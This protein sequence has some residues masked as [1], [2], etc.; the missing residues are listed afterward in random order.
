MKKIVLALVALLMASTFVFAQARGRTPAPAPAAALPE[1]GRLTVE[2]F[3]RGSDG[4]RT[5]AHNNAWTNWIKEKVKKDLNIDVTF[6]PVGRWS[7]NTDIVNLMASGSAPDLC[8][9]YNLD[10]INDFR[11]KGGVFDLAPYIDSYLPDLKKL[12]GKDP[13]FPGKDLAYRDQD[14]KS[15]KIYSVVSYRTAIA[16]RN[17]FIRKDWLDKLGMPLPKNMGEYYQALKAFRDRDPGNVG[18]NRVV[19]LGVNQD[20]RWGL[21][22]FI[23]HFWPNNLSDRDRWIYT[24]ADRQIMMPGYKRGVQEMN[25]WYLEGLIFKDF[26]LMTTAD[27]FY[28]QIKSGVVGSFCQNWDFIYRTDMNILVDLRKNIPT[29]DYVPI[30]ITNNKMVMDKP[31]LR[32]FIPTFS[33]NKDAALKYLNWLAKPENYSFLQIGQAGVTHNMVNGIPQTIATPPQHPWFMNS[34]NNIDITIPMNGVELGSDAQN[35]RVLGL[36]Y[37]TISPDVIS[38]AYVASTTNARGPAVWQATTKVNQ[39]SG[40]LREKADDLIALAITARPANFNK[41][42]DDGI[43]DWLRSG[44]QEVLNERNAL[45]PRR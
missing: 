34:P 18:K 29:A 2:V 5:L 32:I 21:S 6:V 22:D 27:D 14:P 42:W 45:Y 28:N 16:Q 19:P 12:L 26:P 1:T 38:N 20:V 3:D 17:I 36:S 9:T 11:D 24:T 33:P 37:G 31:G 44:G 30:S 25:K 39:Y 13:S 43:K 35:A 10:M 41:V 4:G 15:L 23:H 7:E 8:Y 40:D